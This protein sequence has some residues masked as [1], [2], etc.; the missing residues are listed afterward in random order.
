VS[1]EP[2]PPAPISFHHC[3][4]TGVQRAQVLASIAAGSRTVDDLRRATGVC[5]GCSTC[6]PELRRLLSDVA[7]GRVNPGAGTPPPAPA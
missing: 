5:S 2:D 1:A 4:C 7:A 3:H 6:Y